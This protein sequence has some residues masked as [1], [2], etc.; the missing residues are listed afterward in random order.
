MKIIKTYSLRSRFFENESLPDSNTK[1][2]AQKYSHKKY[3][4][5][6]NNQRY[7]FIGTELVVDFKN[8]D[9]TCSHYLKWKNCCHLLALNNVLKN[10]RLHFKTKRGR[11][12]GRYKYIEKALVHD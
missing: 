8:N 5:S 3:F 6:L 4:K 12:P 2:L 9:C 1:K 11:K 7:N 10:D